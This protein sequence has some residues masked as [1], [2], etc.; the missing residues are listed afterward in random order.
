METRFHDNAV[1][2]PVCDRV[3]QFLAWGNAERVPVHW[4]SGCDAADAL[5]PRVDINEDFWAC[6]LRSV[7]RFYIKVHRPLAPA[8]DRRLLVARLGGA[9][10][11][12]RDGGH[13]ELQ[14]RP[15]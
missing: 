6:P 13:Q 14:A 5:A 9:R 10:C 1:P 3:A 12:H 7:R 15:G 8:R 11:E 2:Q 4:V